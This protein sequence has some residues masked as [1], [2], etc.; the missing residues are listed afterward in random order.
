VA[1]TG[2]TGDGRSAPRRRWTTPGRDTRWEPNRSCAVAH[3]RVQ[4]A[5]DASCVVNRRV[6][7]GVVSDAQRHVVLDHRLRNQAVAHAG[8]ARCQGGEG[9][10]MQER[11]K[12]MAQRSPRGPAAG[13]EIIECWAS[14]G[15]RGFQRRFVQTARA[16][17]SGEVEHLIAD[18][19]PAAPGLAGSGSTEHAERQVLKREVCACGVG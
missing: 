8:H 4:Q 6:E 18:A 9:I 3:P 17:Q 7:I 1:R 11:K 10:L 2:H 13:E 12:R 16:R 5:A 15:N 19:D 14:T